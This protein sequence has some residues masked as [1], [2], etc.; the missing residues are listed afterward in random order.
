[1]AITKARLIS[2]INEVFRRSIE[3]DTTDL[4]DLITDCLVELSSMG[5]FLHSESTIDT[6]EDTYIYQLP[7]DFKGDLLVKIDNERILDFWNFRK[8]QLYLNRETHATGVPYAFS[9]MGGYIESEQVNDE[10]IYVYPVPDDNDG[11]NYTM[12]LFYSAYHPRKI[13][14]GST[15]YD[16][17]D[18]ILFPEQ[19]E[20][21]LKYLVLSNWASDKNLDLDAG[22]YYNLFLSRLSFLKA[23]EEKIYRRV[24]YKDV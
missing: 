21:V 11:D 23:N 3:T 12:R 19:F 20:T 13:T 22:K 16:A 5:N 24:T 17:C 14:V 9:W 8:I 4:D 6:V 10:L 1:M 15:E 2:K 7:E 18:Y